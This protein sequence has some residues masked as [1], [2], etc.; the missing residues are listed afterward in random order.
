MRPLTG[1]AIGYVSDPSILP[2]VYRQRDLAARQRK[3][4]GQFVF[5]A[6][7]GKALLIVK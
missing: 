5:G 1:L 2:E 4:L 3:P 7:W 6:E